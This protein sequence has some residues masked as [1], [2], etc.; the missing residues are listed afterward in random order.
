ML[1]LPSTAYTAGHLELIWVHAHQ[2][3]PTIKA[4]EVEHIADWHGETGKLFDA[5]I[6]CGWLDVVNDETVQVHDYAD[7]A[8][9][10]VKK[11]DYQKE[12][13]REYR[14]RKEPLD[15]VRPNTPNVRQCKDVLDA[16]SVPTQP[17]I[18]KHNITKPNKEDKKEGLPHDDALDKFSQFWEAYPRCANKDRKE[19]ARKKWKSRKLDKQFTEIMEGLEKWTRSKK[20]S[21][22]TYIH[23]PANWIE[24]KMWMEEPQENPGISKDSLK[25]RMLAAHN[26]K[27]LNS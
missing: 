21:D 17:N 7:H 1:E 8:P 3:Q 11:R 2:T 9:S 12:Y 23:N 4:A 13:M 15:P 6:E 24:A 19:A 10:Y 20:W 18:T 5:L 14:K 26:V 27:G 16:V 22:P 25:A